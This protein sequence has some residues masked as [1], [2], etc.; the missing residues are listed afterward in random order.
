MVNTSEQNSCVYTCI[1][2]PNACTVDDTREGM[3][4]CFNKGCDSHFKVKHL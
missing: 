4:R 1:F 2:L 3:Y